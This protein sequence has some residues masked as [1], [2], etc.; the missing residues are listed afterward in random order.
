MRKNHRKT[1]LAIAAALI[2]I[3]VALTA[4]AS[5]N[6]GQLSATLTS[7][8]AKLESANMEK[9]QAEA[10]Y[11]QVSGWNRDTDPLEVPDSCFNAGD[12][13]R[14]ASKMVSLAAGQKDEIRRLQLELQSAASQRDFEKQRASDAEAR[15]QEE[16]EKTEQAMDQ[17][18]QRRESQ[19]ESAEKLDEGAKA[20]VD[21]TV[22]MVTTGSEI[23]QE[24]G[25]K[26]LERF[27]TLEDAHNFLMEERV[28]LADDRALL[29][30]TV[31][32]YVERNTRVERER[33]EAERKQAEQRVEAA[34]RRTATA[35]NAR[36]IALIDSLQA[37]KES[38]KT[39]AIYNTRLQ[40]L[41]KK[42][43]AFDGKKASNDAE[44]RAAWTSL[45]ASINNILQQ[46][47]LL[48]PAQ[49]DAEHSSR[50]AEVQYRLNVIRS[51]WSEFSDVCRVSR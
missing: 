10:C 47:S 8:R 38:E 7:E 13:G 26:W 34:E 25:A 32:D 11:A 1:G 45:D 44:C 6:S 48:P 37:V 27:E 21:S 42:E 29:D 36:D 18:T 5:D 20:I 51:L 31:A 39:V 33:L 46:T 2:A 16:A 24:A 30:A 50:V 49:D 9:S 19:I 17:L 15:M 3:L 41:S 40:E 12:A 28:Q 35:E 22:T 23:A 4:C 14:V 43:A